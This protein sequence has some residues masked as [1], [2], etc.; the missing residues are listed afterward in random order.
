MQEGPVCCLW[1]EDGEK[2]HVL[3]HGHRTERTLLF[4][5][6]GIVS[7]FVLLRLSLQKAINFTHPPF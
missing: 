2:A 5:G 4:R 6:W 7:V 3:V 1:S